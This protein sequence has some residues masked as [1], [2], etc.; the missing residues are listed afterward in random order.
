M[1]QSFPC[2]GDIILIDFNPQSGIE[3]MKRLRI[4]EQAVIIKPAREN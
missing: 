3:I 4:I 2:T 1:S